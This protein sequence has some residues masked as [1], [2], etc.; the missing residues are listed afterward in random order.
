M[1]ARLTL[2][3]ANLRFEHGQVVVGNVTETHVYGN[4]HYGAASTI[5]LAN[6]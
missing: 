5:P 4:L 1:F 3:S 2:T 6:Q